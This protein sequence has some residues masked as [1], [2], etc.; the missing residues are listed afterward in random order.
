MGACVREVGFSRYIVRRVLNEEGIQLSG[1]G[2]PLAKPSCGT[3]AAY[4]RH[5]RNGEPVDDACRQANTRERRQKLEE[6]PTKRIPSIAYQRTLGE[7]GRRHSEELAEYYAEELALEGESTPKT[8]SAARA[9]TLGRIA[10][11]Y[12]DERDCLRAAYV[13]QI[14]AERDLP[15]V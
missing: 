13:A 7:L 1:P 15:T 10:R 4:N 2:R 14:R 3:R 12:P 8:R 9:R 11:K 5:L 6:D